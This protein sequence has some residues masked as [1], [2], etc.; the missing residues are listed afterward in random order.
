MRLFYPSI[1]LT[2]ATVIFTGCKGGANK[3]TINYDY[4]VKPIFEMNCLECHGENGM[5]NLNLSTYDDL[6]KG[7]SDNGPVV[8]P[9]DAENSLLYQKVSREDPPIGSRMP[10]GRNPLPSSQIRIIEE[11]ILQGAKK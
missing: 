10:Y 11:W 8:I 1:M 2:V 3:T 7:D 6:M 4:D 9:Y 5:A